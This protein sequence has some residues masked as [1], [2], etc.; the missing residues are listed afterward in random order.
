MP[1][2]NGF[3]NNVQG[4]INELFIELTSNCNLRCRYCALNLQGYEGKDMAS[5]HVDAVLQ[6]VELNRVPVV[7]IN[8]HGETTLI[9]NWI[10]ISQRLQALGTQINI[11]SNFA[12]YFSDKEVRA[13][14]GFSGIRISIDSVDR[15]L[16]RSIRYSVDFRIILHNLTRV[17]AA[18]LAF[19]GRMPQFGINCVV[20]DRN[21]MTISE[22]VA[23]A[24]ANGFSDLTL[25]DL[26]ELTDL[27]E[28][29]PKHILKMSPEK[30]RDALQ[31][32]SDA[33]LLAK[34]LGL[35]INI[36]PNLAMLLESDTESEFTLSKTQYFK[37]D[38]ETLVLITPLS[39]G[40]TRLCFDPWRIAKI[41][42]DGSVM[43]CC[44]GRI[45]LG[46]LDDSSLEDIYQNEAIQNRRK[47]L[48]SGDLS[49]EC[50]FCPVRIAIPVTEFRVKLKEFVQQVHTKIII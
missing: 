49:R 27:P 13:L 4:S 22:L 46:H 19:H 25:H 34:R 18:A 50:R 48:L 21:V 5:H 3:A 15:E 12:R 41:T 14:A 11:I 23:F 38:S 8:V 37:E 10:E 24:A 39:S 28:D 40:T 29:R 33:V 36:Q 26:A 9:K 16:L 44:I 43:S 6:Y 42:E 45:R 47:E 1:I 32:I 30:K 7:S 31:A 17:R 20:S 2:T 35:L